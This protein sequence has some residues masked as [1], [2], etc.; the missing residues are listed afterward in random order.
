MFLELILLIQSTGNLHDV[1]QKL[2][3][4]K[5]KVSN[6]LYPL[7]KFRRIFHKF[8]GQEGLVENFWRSKGEISLSLGKAIYRRMIIHGGS[9]DCLVI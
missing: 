6:I 9:G 2:I 8:S 1:L 5:L 3:H 4:D 7:K